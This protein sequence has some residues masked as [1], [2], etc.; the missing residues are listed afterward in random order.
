MSDDDVMQD[1]VDDLFSRMSSARGPS[2]GMGRGPGHPWYGVVEDT[3]ALWITWIVEASRRLGRPMP[4]ALKVDGKLVCLACVKLTFGWRYYFECPRCGNRCE[5]IYFLRRDASGCRRCLHLGY[6]SQMH[7]RYSPYG[8]LD[9]M[10]S[11]GRDLWRRYRINGASEG[12]VTET[13]RE[14]R[15]KLGTEIENML[16]RVDVVIDED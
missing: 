8:E 5:A 15:N 1:Y 7:R 2:S 3:P 16:A 11:R 12:L 10:F 4:H 6:R 14:L 13:L 9:R